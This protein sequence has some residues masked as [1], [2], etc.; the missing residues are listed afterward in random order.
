MKEQLEYLS[1]RQKERIKEDLKQYQEGLRNLR[2]K[3]TRKEYT[4]MVC[5]HTFKS[6]TI[7]R[8][9]PIICYKCFDKQFV[10]F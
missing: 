8:S 9:S 6:P 5:F 2:Y 3:D 1:A 10:S 7:N 4:C